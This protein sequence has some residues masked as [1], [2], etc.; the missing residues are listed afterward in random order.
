LISV[1]TEPKNMLIRHAIFHCELFSW[2]IFLAE[3]EIF[4]FVDVGR[5]SC[6]CLDDHLS[7]ICRTAWYCQTC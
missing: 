7:A 3:C 1:M 4:N 6:H 2:F 5:H